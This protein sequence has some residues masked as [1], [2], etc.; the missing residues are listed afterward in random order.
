MKEE[1]WTTKKGKRI[2]VSD[3][4]EDHV[5]HCLR[6]LIRYDADRQDEADIWNECDATEADLY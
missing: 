6:M 2:A 1:Y 4:D 3:M 5:R